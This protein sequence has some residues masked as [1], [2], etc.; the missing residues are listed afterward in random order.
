MIFYNNPYRYGPKLIIVLTFSLLIVSVFNYFFYYESTEAVSSS[1]RLFAEAVIIVLVIKYKLVNFK[2]LVNFIVLVSV[3]N[4]LV[5]IL[6]VIESL[7]YI[8]TNLNSLVDFWGV[9]NELMRKPGFLNSILTSSYI[10]FFGLVLNLMYQPKI[11]KYFII[12]QLCALFFSARTFL[13]PIFFMIPIFFIFK[14]SFRLKLK[15]SIFLFF[16][17]FLVSFVNAE[18]IQNLVWH[19]NERVLPAFNVIFGLDLKADYSSRD[20]IS[21]YRL[22]TFSEFIIG[23]GFPR[24]SELGGADPTYTRW[25][26]QA[27]FLAFSLVFLL[28]LMLL[29]FLSY[30]KSIYNI[31]LGCVLFIT[32]LKGELTTA[33]LL[34]S[35]TF[36]YA[37]LGA[38]NEFSTE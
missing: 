34:F 18:L 9:E 23:N 3:L 16:S 5:V 29:F 21:H 35:I 22:P 37:L 17:Y 4:S 32:P 36:L 25:L 1:I 13:M 38:K 26:L 24:Y 28:N 20:L 19:F 12:I 33:T 10:I 30:K 7:G 31:L 11:F 2:C 27:G 6:Q 14:F 8:S 15:V